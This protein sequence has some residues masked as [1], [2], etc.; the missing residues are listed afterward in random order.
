LAVGYRIKV[1]KGIEELFDGGSIDFAVFE[2]KGV[3]FKNFRNAA[4]T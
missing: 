3:L 2:V 1:V 4:A